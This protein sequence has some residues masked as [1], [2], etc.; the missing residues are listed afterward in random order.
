MPK[1]ARQVEDN[2]GKIVIAAEDTPLIMELGFPDLI[3]DYKR[4]YTKEVEYFIKKKAD[5]AFIKAV[6]E[7]S[8]A[9]TVTYGDWRST[10]IKPLGGKKLD[11]TKLMRNMMLLG[12]LSAD[13]AQ[14]VITASTIDKPAKNPYLRIFAP[15][16]ALP[17][18]PKGTDDDE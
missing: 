10:V 11:E 7:A 13:L 1:A 12:K 17:K 18:R 2:D 5:Q 16:G 6:V 8:N 9:D 4:H 14:A 3:T 15:D